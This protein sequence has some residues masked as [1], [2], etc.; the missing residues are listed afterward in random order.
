MSRRLKKKK[1]YEIAVQLMG[2]KVKLRPCEDFV[3]NYWGDTEWIECTRYFK[4][5]S[6]WYGGWIKI[7]R[8]WYDKKYREHMEVDVYSEPCDGVYTRHSY[9]TVM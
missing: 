6:V 4:V 9:Y 2:D 5:T 7:E 1:L 8:I 3:Y